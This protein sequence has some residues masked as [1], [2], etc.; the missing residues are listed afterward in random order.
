MEAQLCFTCH[1]GWDDFWEVDW[2]DYPEDA[3]IDKEIS[4]IHGEIIEIFVDKQFVDDV[5][6]ELKASYDSC[7]NVDFA[8]L[9]VVVQVFIGF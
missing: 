2:S 7:E 9:K 8:F 3:L 1:W 4:W 6:V 5:E